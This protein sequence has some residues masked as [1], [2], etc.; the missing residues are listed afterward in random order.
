MRSI[1]M[2]RAVH[3]PTVAKSDYKSLIRQS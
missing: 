1:D 2:Q 3:S